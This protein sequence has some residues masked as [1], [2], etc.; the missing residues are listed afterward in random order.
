MYPNDPTTPPEQ[1]EQSSMPPL[2][3]ESESEST[4]QPDMTQPQMQEPAPQ[5]EPAMP[6]QPSQPEQP[7]YAPP[8]QQAYEAQ[9]AH[10]PGK[11]LGIA[12]FVLAFF[13][14]IVGLPLSIVA[15][16]KSKKANMKNGLALA[17]II[18]NSVFLVVGVAFI[19]ITVMAYTGIQQRANSQAAA[20]TAQEVVKMAEMYNIDNAEYDGDQLVP[21][22]PK[23]FGDIASMVQDVT[24]AKAPIL[25]APAGPSAIEFYTCG[26]QTGN[27]VGYWDYAERDVKYV[28]AGEASASS[29]DCTLATE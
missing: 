13:L 3:P 21:R 20:N 19:A 18:L 6:E 28:Y 23:K 8:V 22:Y 9:P 14:P 12:G 16:L 27:K 1:P 11:G 10:N 15:F 29:T 7:A 25:F 5:V 24:F 26:D 17:G 2:Q 4:Q